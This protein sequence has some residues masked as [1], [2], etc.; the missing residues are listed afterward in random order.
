MNENKIIKGIN[1]I[2]SQSKFT[3]GKKGRNINK[4]ISSSNIYLNFIGDNVKNYENKDKLSNINNIDESKSI[5]DENIKKY[6]NNIKRTLVDEDEKEK[7]MVLIYDKFINYY[8]DKKYEIILNEI[9]GI[10]IYHTNSDTS[11]KI[12]M[13]KIRCLL[14]SLKQ[15]YVKL[16]KRSELSN[17]GEIL[18]KITK[19]TKD[20]EKTAEYISPYHSENYE[21]ITEVYAK[22]LL[23]LS[24]LSKHKEEFIKSMAYLTMGVNLMKLFFIRRKVAKNIKTYIIFIQ[25]LLLLI[26]YLIGDSNISAA[27]FYSK[28]LFRILE[29]TYKIL[30][31]D[32]IKKKYYLKILEYSG[33]NCLYFGI[34]LEQI[35]DLTID[36]TCFL[37][38]KQ[39]KYF[40][41]IV[42][43]NTP[44]RKSF[45][46]IITK[47]NNENIVLLLSKFLIEKY[48]NLVEREKYKI[49]ILKYINKDKKKKKE[50]ILDIVLLENMRKKK[51][52]IIENKIYKNILTPNNQINIEKLDN[53]LISVIYQHK[54][55]KYNPISPRNKKFLYNFE[56]YNILMSNGFRNYL[57]EN[58][59]LQ[60]NN[61][62]VEKQSIQNLQRY[63][64]KNIKIGDFVDIN[65]NYNPKSSKNFLNNDSNGNKLN[66]KIIENDKRYKGSKIILKKNILRKYIMKNKSLSSNNIFSP[67]RSSKSLDRKDK[68]NPFA[69]YNRAYK[70][71]KLFLNRNHSISNMSMSKKTFSDINSSKTVKLDKKINFDYFKL[72]KENKKQ[73]F[74]GVNNL[75]KIK[76]VNMKNLLRRDKLKNSSRFRYSNSYSCLENDF[77]RKYLDKSILSSKYLKKISYLD[78]CTVKELAFQKTMLKL[79]GNN[80]KM[81]IETYEQDYKDNFND[82]RN[83]K[84]SAYNKFLFLNDKVNHQTN[85]DKIEDYNDKKNQPN[86]LEYSSN[87]Y[88]V[89]NK[90]VQTSK[91]K[92]A[93]R[94]KLYSQSFQ[95]VKRNNEVKI[96]NLNRGLKELN[97]IM[98]YKNKQIKNFSFSKNNKFN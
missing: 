67:N 79:K 18:K 64:N 3:I 15:Q 74:F 76:N 93:K 50:K 26:N 6:F 92:A 49:K 57:V 25:I 60:F 58:N 37:V 46:Q 4:L 68:I 9:S 34:C 70:S 88:K 19:I 54:N 77:E 16:L 94:L 90:Y 96:L 8:K 20:F 10:N 33:Y 69:S 31:K 24:M 98:S 62:F 82:K 23:Y 41:Q 52:N 36:D 63:L 47:S 95:N 39:A 84:E 53:E 55:E 80:S 61:P 7:Q 11:F 13:L 78:S 27:I 65:P 51:Y 42:E 17:F 83:V 1:F 59:K 45:I 89:F 12:Y 97:Y 38:Y 66:F 14:K 72:I 28:M 91:E 75:K 5:N 48:Q 22:Y 32:T 35:V 56:L 44:K 43:N 85:N 71:Q 86:I 2:F 30:L 87:I 40:L 21:E 81:F 73:N 29:V